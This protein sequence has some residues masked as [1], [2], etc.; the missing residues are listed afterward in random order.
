MIT[1][2]FAIKNRDKER[3]KNCIDSL[4]NQ[5]CKIIVVDFGS[6]DLSW[7]SEVFKTGWISIRRDTDDWNKCRAYNIGLRLVTT[8]YVVFSDIDNI[9]APNFI[10]RVK[11]EIVKEKSVVLCQCEDLDEQGKVYRLHLK[12]GY[13][14]CFG[15]D[16][17]WIKS[18]NGYDENFT[19]WGNEDT[20][21]AQ[22][23][24]Q[25]GYNLI[26]LE[27]LIK[28]QW[29]ENAPKPTLS[30]NRRYFEKKKPVVREQEWGIL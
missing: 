29:H 7:Y 24:N 16:T 11:E 28:H 20:D 13:G 14:A 12:T 18:V 26:W 9:F 27:P 25:S 1:V 4:I 3:A 30:K 8:P 17:N 10:D 21:I 22:R 15:I 5:D 23:A 2:V 19:Y 6:D